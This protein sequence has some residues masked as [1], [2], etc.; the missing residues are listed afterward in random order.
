MNRKHIKSALSALALMI[1]A[2]MAHAWTLEECIKEDTAKGPGAGFRAD[3][4]SCPNTATPEGRQA[5]IARAQQQLD[6]ANQNYT[7]V[8]AS[9][10]SSAAARS[11]AQAAANNAAT[12]LSNVSALGGAGGQ[13]TGTGIGTGGTGTANA[14]GANVATTT[15]TVNNNR[16]S[17]INLKP[18]DPVY[19][20]VQGV[21]AGIKSRST[22]GTLVETYTQPLEILKVGPFGGVEKIKLEGLDTEKLRPV[23]EEAVDDEGN[24]ILDKD[25]KPV[26][27]EK[28]YEVVENGDGTVS[29]MG[30]VYELATVPV[31]ASVLAQFNFFAAK[32]ET[33]TGG[34]AGAS[35]G[36]TINQRFYALGGCEFRRIRITPAKVEVKVEVSA[37][38]GA[39]AEVFLPAVGPAAKCTTPTCVCGKTNTGRTV[40]A[41]N[42][43][44]ACIAQLR[45]A[46]LGE[47]EAKA[48]LLVDDNVVA[49]KT[50][51]A[52]AG[53]KVEATITVPK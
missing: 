43:P 10:H 41:E 9:P 11:A 34:G 48:V 49:S 31:Q 44:G 26:M 50:V 42:K 33:S 46:G 16:A 8:Q 17:T 6:N 37:T 52:K 18:G 36:I 14:G 13:G 32:A 22:C 19:P 38:A 29:W 45:A 23:M 21:P 25:R 2:S 24:P 53:Q 4:N 30:S 5:A 12:L 20:I 15:T 47:A 51:K 1:F 27:R 35:S 7:S 40:T 28:K 39:Q 3:P